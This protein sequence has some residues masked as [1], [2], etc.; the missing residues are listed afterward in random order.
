[1]EAFFSFLQKLFVFVFVLAT[2]FPYVQYHE[3]LQQ[4]ETMQSSQEQ[5]ERSKFKWPIRHDSD[6]ISIDEKELEWLL[7]GLDIL[8]QEPHKTLHY[9]SVS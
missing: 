7:S 4:K 2:F 1:M 9:Q 8:P 3:F 5:L 6:V